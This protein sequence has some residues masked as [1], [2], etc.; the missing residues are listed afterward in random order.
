[1]IFNENKSEAVRDRHASLQWAVQLFNVFSDCSAHETK[2]SFQ[3]ISVDKKL[4]T[5]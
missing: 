4:K 3:E 5:M 1:L 2:I